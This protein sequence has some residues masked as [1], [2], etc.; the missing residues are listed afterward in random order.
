M[1]KETVPAY[2]TVLRR[3]ASW[4]YDYG[5]KKIFAT[6][7]KNDVE[8]DSQDSHGSHS[9]NWKERS[10]IVGVMAGHWGRFGLAAISVETYLAEEQKI[11]H[12]PKPD[13]YGHCD[14][15]GKKP[16][17]RRKRLR[18]SARVL[19]PPPPN[20]PED[21]QHLHAIRGREFNS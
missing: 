1:P 8:S 12:S 5:S 19:I 10:T 3:I 11:T 7:F 6:A 15:I 16:D 20:S 21:Y 17:K 14:A 13:N 18:D 4:Q 9:V 2:A